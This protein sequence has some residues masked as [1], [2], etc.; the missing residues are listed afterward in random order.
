[1]KYLVLVTALCSSTVYAAGDTFLR[2]DHISDPGVGGDGINM[3]GIGSAWRPE[4]HV[5]FEISASHAIT[6]NGFSY[7]P[8]VVVQLTGKLNFWSW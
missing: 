7:D 4:P 1:M 8:G 2:F 6:D 3:I 5:T